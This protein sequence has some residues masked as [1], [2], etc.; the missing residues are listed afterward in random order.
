[1][2]FPNARFEVLEAFPEGFQVLRAERVE[3]SV[4]KVNDAGF[5]RAR[6]IVRRDDLRGDGFEFGG[7]KGGEYLEAG[8]LAGRP[9]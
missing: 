4:D 9:R 8:F 6:R 7:F 5:T 2:F 3:R 1:M